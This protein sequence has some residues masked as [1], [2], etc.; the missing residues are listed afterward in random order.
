M[1]IALAF[2]KEKAFSIISF[3]PTKSNPC[4]NFPTAPITPDN[5]I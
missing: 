3:C 5:L 2:L 1:A 4:L